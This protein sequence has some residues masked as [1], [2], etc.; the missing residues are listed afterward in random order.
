MIILLAIIGLVFELSGAYL[1]ALKQLKIEIFG[2]RLER[3]FNAS[4]PPHLQ[5]K[6]K[7]FSRLSIYI[8]DIL[9]YR[10][11]KVLKDISSKSDEVKKDTSKETRDRN[12]VLFSFILLSLGFIIQA[13]VIIISSSMNRTN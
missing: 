12:K 1:L 10:L 5:S 11:P 13:V 2:N 7:Y 8:G 6:Q 4:L 3:Y 9:F